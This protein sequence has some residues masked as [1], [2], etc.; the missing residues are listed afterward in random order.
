MSRA[1]CGSLAL[2]AAA[3]WVPPASGAERFV[4]VAAERGVVF[5][6]RD[7]R[8]GAKYYVET[9]A[10]GG[11]WL[12]YDGDG[13]LDLYL[14]QGA[15]PPGSPLA[16]ASNVL[17]ENREGRFVDVTELAGVGDSSFSMGLCAG[18]IDADGRLDFLV[19]NFGPDRLYRNQGA[20]RFAE[21]G[22]VAGVAGRGWSSS[23]AF[24]DIDGDGD[25]DLYVTHYLDFEYA[26][27]PDCTE[28]ATRRRLYCQP[29]AF[30]GVTDSLFVNKGDGTFREEGRQRGLAVG[31]AEKGMGVLMVDLD[32]DG[33]LD[34]YVANDGT[35]NRHYVNDGRGNFIDE[36]L[37][38]GTAVNVFGQPEA[39][40]GLAAGD[41]DGDGL[42][43]LVLT[44]FALETNTLYRASSRGQYDD[45]SRASGIGPLS[46]R[47]VG[48]GV[49]LFDADND[50][51]LDLAV[52]NGHIEDDLA[53]IEPGLEYAQPR[54]LL[55]NQGDGSFRDI[56]AESGE[57]WGRK[58]IGRGLAAG[59]FNDDGRVDLLITNT[60]G[61]T[62]LLE[63]RWHSENHW[64]GVSLTGPAA[65]PLA[66]GATL[67]LRGG[68]H[69][70]VRE[71]SSGGSFQSQSD[72]RQ[73]FGL[74]RH[75][76][77]VELEVR[78]PDG[79]RQVERI[80]TVDRY[81]PVVYAPPKP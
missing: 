76:G 70:Q 75:G 11:G 48:W 24:G 29:T 67:W 36:G 19:T 57:V 34:I 51:D 18:D 38:S 42:V 79:T 64:L 74:G 72:L 17:Y 66:L 3:T 55:E 39:S 68:D 9:T 78:W 28:P 58:N 47:Y 77:P 81:W 52:V 23:C 80:E 56:A 63:N 27:N 7:F 22:G 54:W 40:M 65:N 31:A 45:V 33:D 4:D 16:G 49:Q 50:G 8:D 25:Q 59:D 41:V 14:L 2:L 69:E 46:L 53:A 15:P 71:V 12:D 43:D 60:N 10:S 62:E 6:H 73:H 44:H 37:M 5:Q 26:T 20:G 13:D 61:R 35:P 21:V 1:W 30:S 32:G